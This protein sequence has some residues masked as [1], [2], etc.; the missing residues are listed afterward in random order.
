MKIIFIVPPTRDAQ[1]PPIVVPPL[2][3]LYLAGAIMQSGRSA[4][5][6]DAQAEGLSWA[7]FERRAAESDAQIAAIGSMT[8][9]WDVSKRA[10][11]ILKRAGKIV[12]I[13]GPHVTMRREKYFE[14]EK[15]AQADFAVAGEAEQTILDV[16]D[17]VENNRGGEDIAGV[18]SKNGKHK[19]RELTQDIDS[20]PRPAR[21]L[22]KHG[23]YS[24][25]LLGE[26]P[27]ATIFTSRGCPHSCVFCDKS[28]FG[29]R[30]RLHS[31]D[32][33]IDELKEIVCGAGVNSVIIYDDLFTVDRNRVIE[34]CRR[35]IDSG[36]K[37]RWK[38]EGRVDGVDAEMLKWMRRAGCEIVAYGIETAHAAGL[39]FLCKGASP[40]DAARSIQMTRE[41]GMDVVGYFLIGIPGERI[42]HTRET[43][44]FAARWGVTW[45]QFSVL[46]PIEGTRLYETAVEN[47]WYGEANALNPFDADLS[48]PALL[49]G[50]WTPERLRDALYV[51]HR[52]FYARPDYVLSQLRKAR[53]IA[54]AK[55]IIKSGLN[56]L[57]WMSKSK[58]KTS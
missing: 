56:L 42:E 15:D 30:P 50:Y 17:A 25:P 33:V 18:I 1:R 46:S 35:I 27:A 34:I 58:F 53:G 22:L 6:L 4:E 11:A 12:L 16:L 26:G 32:R 20:L 43:A 7:D 23:L 28:V 39:R 5:L 8:P 52:E 51:A 47:N 10:V 44:R 3:L 14:I 45:A 55:N 40:I 49:D 31:P 29:S 24:Y 36:L 2:G 48:R 19:P 41:A 57:S 38:C 9:T 54:G 21:K 37:F 13:G